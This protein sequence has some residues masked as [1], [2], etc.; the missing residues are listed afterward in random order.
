MRRL[1]FTTLLLA[2]GITSAVPADDS[3]LPAP[4]TPPAEIIHPKRTLSMADAVGQALATD[5]RLQAAQA[6]VARQRHLVYQA[7]RR[8]N[9]S[10]GY[11]ASEIGQEGQAGQQGVYLAQTLRVP[12]KRHLDGTIR[13]REVAIASRQ[14]DLQQFISIAFARLT[15]VD[16]AAGQRRIELLGRLQASLD[17]AVKGIK[18]QVDGGEVARSALLQAQIEAR[19]NRIALA[20]ARADYDA[21]CHRLA[22]VLGRSAFHDQVETSILDAAPEPPDYDTIWATIDSSS[23]EIA[24]A[25]MQHNRAS[26][27]VQRQRVEPYSDLQTQWTIQQDAATNFTVAG[28]QVSFE[29]PVYDK[30]RGAINSARAENR[31]TH[32]EVAS[33]RRQ[34]RIRLAQTLGRYQQAWQQLVAMQ[35]DLQLLAKD[36]LTTIESDFWSGDATYLELLNSQRTFI[37]IS[38]DTLDSQRDIARETV[39]LETLLVPVP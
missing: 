36:N 24:I 14:L 16:V 39:R 17:G 2:G 4:V 21:A 29:L 7:T 26:W 18:I 35:N 13:Q 25:A 34:L 31:R 20:R 32:H 30:N 38:L 28:V 5:P 23:P 6:A 12:R 27:V 8:Q 3:I 33:V 11:A 37:S 1:L 10:V 22:G 15:F 19:R 9:P